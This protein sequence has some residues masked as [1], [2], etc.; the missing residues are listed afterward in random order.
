MF[1]II[2]YLLKYKKNIDK[3]FFNVSYTN[4]EIYD[5]MYHYNWKII[6]YTLNNY[7]KQLKKVVINQRLLFIFLLFTVITSFFL[8]ACNNRKKSL[9]K[10]SQHPTKQLINQNRETQNNFNK[11]KAITLAIEPCWSPVVTLKIFQPFA[12]YLSNITHLKVKL[13][14]VGSVGAFEKLVK[15]CDFV[16]LQSYALYVLNNSIHPCKLIPLAIAVANDGSTNEF[17]WIIV[18][19]DSR[20]KTIRDLKNKTFIFGTPLSTQKYFAAYITLKKNGIDPLK[21]LKHFDFGPTCRYNALAVYLGEFDAGAICQNYPTITKLFNFKNDLRIIAPT[22]RLPNWFFATTLH[23]AKSIKRLF[24]KVVLGLNP[25]EETG[26]KIFHFM[27]WKG[28]VKTNRKDITIIKKLIHKYH[29]PQGIIF[30]RG[31]TRS[32]SVQSNS[33]SSSLYYRVYTSYF[34]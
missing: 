26:R 4:G 10:E 17:G 16:L 20:I 22:I 30:R 24:K 7:L 8:Y 15:N 5:S 32:Q 3:K 29:V 23:T 11:I 27:K 1:I 28:F 6:F 2:I 12:D 33:N 25:K 9:S 13:K 31:L 21:D 34:K 18:R 14:I 19:A